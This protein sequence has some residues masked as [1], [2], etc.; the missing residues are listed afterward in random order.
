[1]ARLVFHPPPVTE[2][3]SA[4]FISLLIIVILLF[5][6][7]VSFL[8]LIPSHHELRDLLNMTSPLNKVSHVTSF[9]CFPQAMDLL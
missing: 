7:L 6:F 1:M 9:W 3:R 2:A 8:N 5:L 4:A